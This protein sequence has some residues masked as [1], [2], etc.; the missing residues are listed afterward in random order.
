MIAADEDALI[1]DLAETYGIL[2]YKA[3]SVPL[4][5]T[6]CV[7]L[8]DYFRIKIKISGTKATQET[9]L[10]AAVVD[11]LSFI[12]WTKTKGAEKGKGRPKPILPFVM[13]KEEK[14]KAIGFDTAE[15]FQTARNKILEGGNGN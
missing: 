3:L 5:A 12:A 10:L 15:E 2:D 8:G 9:L 7:G 6:L 13:G 14:R 11:R 4:L 1:C